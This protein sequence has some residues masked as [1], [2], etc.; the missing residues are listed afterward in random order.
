M[1]YNGENNFTNNLQWE[2]ST[3]Q[4]FQNRK[5]ETYSK[6]LNLFLLIYMELNFNSS[7]L[8]ISCRKLELSLNKLIESGLNVNAESILY[9]P[10]WKFW[11]SG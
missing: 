9:K 7:R 3:H 2:L 4:I 11:V 5:Q 10:K 1:Y 8:E 6:E